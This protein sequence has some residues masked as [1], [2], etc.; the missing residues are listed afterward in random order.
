MVTLMAVHM[1]KRVIN[2]QVN[3]RKSGRLKS[4]RNGNVADDTWDVQDRGG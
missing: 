1:R 3:R 2:M 4:R